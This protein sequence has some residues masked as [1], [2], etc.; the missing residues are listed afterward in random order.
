[1]RHLAVH[2]PDAQKDEA[3]LED[4][5]IQLSDIHQ[6]IDENSQLIVTNIDE[7]SLDPQ[8]LQVTLSPQTQQTLSGEHLVVFEVIQTN[9]DTNSQT[10]HVDLD[11]DGTIILDQTAIAIPDDAK[12]MRES[13]K[14][15]DLAECF[16]FKNDDEED[17]AILSMP[18][19]HAQ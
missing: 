10:S 11:Q 2:D 15:K 5:S 17:E 14:Q 18:A 8:I 12:A 6:L 7:E 1:M 9:E 19:A 13:Q 4:G 3:Y 16:G